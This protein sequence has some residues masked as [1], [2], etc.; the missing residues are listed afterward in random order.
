[1][2]RVVL[3]ALFSCALCSLAK[4]AR[5]EEGLFLMR[6]TGGVS[7]VHPEIPEPGQMW[8]AS[9][10]LTL[11]EKTGII[12]GAVLVLHDE[13]RSLALH[14]GI[15]HL[16][17]EGFWN[18]IYLHISPEALRIWGERQ[19]KRYDLGLRGGLGYE[20]T[21]TWGLGLTIELHG[22][23][24]IGLGDAKPLDAATVGMTAGFFMEF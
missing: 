22:S 1:M 16:L 21:L 2:K 4:Q 12:G 11:G 6:L 15:K 9:A 13:A 10:D 7:S 3:L 5:A 19:E 14:L 20:H 24:P 17:M 23:A 18:R 8:N